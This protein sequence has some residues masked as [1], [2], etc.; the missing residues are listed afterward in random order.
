MKQLLIG[1]M[2]TEG[3]FGTAAAMK[4]E[5]HIVVNKDNS[6]TIIKANISKKDCFILFEKSDLYYYLLDEIPEKEQ[7]FV[8]M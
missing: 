6:R 1:T 5:R 2:I 7:S 8:S 4:R 3:I